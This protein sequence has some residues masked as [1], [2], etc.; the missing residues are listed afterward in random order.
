MPVLETWSDLQAE[1]TGRTWAL[2]VRTALSLH[3][4]T[5][6]ECEVVW[7]LLQGKST[8]EIA[9]ALDMAEQTLKNH[10]GHLYEKFGVHDRLQLALRVLGVTA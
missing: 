2:T 4:A 5:P 8:C 6:R 9:A 7:Q 3:E 1:L 10:M